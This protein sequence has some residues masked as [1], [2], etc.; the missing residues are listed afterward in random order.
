ML[1]GIDVVE[2]DRIR[3]ALE[4]HPRLAERLFTPGEREYCL[5]RPDPTPHLAARFAAKEAVG[6][7]LGTGVISWQ[8]IEIGRG[9]GPVVSLSGNTAAVA[10]EKGVT[11]ISVSL[12]HGRD[13]SVAAALCDTNQPS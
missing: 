12:S 8:E 5:S 2:N 13:V 9:G 6:K 11:S 3:A 4:R 1:I 7:A 10:A